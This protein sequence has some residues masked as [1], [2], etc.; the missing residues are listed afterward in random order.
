MTDNERHLVTIDAAGETVRVP[1]SL[2]TK[3]E[4][5]SH[6]AR[7][8]DVPRDAVCFVDC[9]PSHLRV[10]LECLRHDD[11]SVD[12]PLAGG[13][14]RTAARLG[15]VSMAETL[16]GQARAPSRSSVLGLSDDECAHL[17]AELTRLGDYILKGKKSKCSS[18]WTTTG[19]A[20][21]S[22]QWARKRHAQINALLYPQFDE[23]RIN[24]EA[25]AVEAQKQQQQQ[26]RRQPGF[27]DRVSPCDVKDCLALGGLLT[28][29]L[30]F[31]GLIYALKRAK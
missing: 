10:I 13:V 6:L 15:L 4:K 20:E 22:Q 8:V 27:W 24:R 29:G 31:F 25:A 30:S 28:F 12:A 17:R 7:L 18:S 3:C 19:T 9:D 23:A 26:Q 5:D 1:A 2:L 16:C 21:D 11:Y 14:A